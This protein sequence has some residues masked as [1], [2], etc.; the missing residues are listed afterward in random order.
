MRRTEHIPDRRPPS[1]RFTYRTLLGI[2]SGGDRVGN[3]L[4]VPFLVSLCHLPDVEHGLE[5]DAIE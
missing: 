3:L 2:G 5:L 1:L 4:I